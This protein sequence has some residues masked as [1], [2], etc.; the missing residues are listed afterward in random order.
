MVKC[1]KKLSTKTIHIYPQVR[2]MK[3][4]RNRSYTPSYPHYPHFWMC[5]NLFCGDKIKNRRFVDCDKSRILM[6]K[7]EI[8]IDF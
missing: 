2:W 7:V 5:I 1:G 3:S 4:R 8:A 6:K